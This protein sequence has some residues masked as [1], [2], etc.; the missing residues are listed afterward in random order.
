[1]TQELQKAGASPKPQK[2]ITW[3]RVSAFLVD[4]AVLVVLAIGFGVLLS[5]IFGF[6]TY[7]EA[8]QAAYMRYEEVYDTSFELTQA[9]Y[10]AMTQEERDR[11]DQ[12]YEALIADQEA[13]YAYNMTIKLTLGV[14]TLSILITVILLELV[15]PL[16][17]GNGQTLGKK[18]LGLSVMRTDGTSLAISQLLIRTLVGKYIIEIMIPVLLVVL[19]FFNIIGLGGLIV[20]GGIV[21][22]QVISMWISK[23][24]AAIHDRLAG[25]VVVEASPRKERKY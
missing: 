9:D 4:A 19:L 11:Y 10:E 21:L 22:L 14:T 15:G 3:K 16:L 2:A 7:N 13:M 12:A 18:M 23:T 20:A 1:M 24:N 6:A 8:V 17:L 25:T 5:N